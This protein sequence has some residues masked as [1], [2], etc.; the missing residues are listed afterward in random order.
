MSE[1]V[2]CRYKVTFAEGSGLTAVGP[3][4]EDPDHFLLDE[5]DPDWVGDPELG[6]GWRQWTIMN[7]R[8]G[9]QTGVIVA[10]LVGPWEAP[11]GQE[12]TDTVPTHTS[13]SD[14]DQSY[15]PGEA[16]SGP[17]RNESEHSCL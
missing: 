6:R 5:A 3:D 13:P 12:G 11:S 9:E 1:T 8:T 2:L 10:D 7:F 17:V 4:W 16:A 15:R 14:R